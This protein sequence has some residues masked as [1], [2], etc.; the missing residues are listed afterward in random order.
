[1]I[2][3]RSF[4]GVTPQVIDKSLNL[5]KEIYNDDGRIYLET[6]YT[7]QHVE[8]GL[9]FEYKYVLAINDY[10]QWMDSI[11][12]EFPYFAEL[13]LIPTPESLDKQVLEELA[14]SNGVE[15]DEVL[16]YDLVIEG[17]SVMLGA[18][19]GL[20]QIMDR[21]TGNMTDNEVCEGFT[22]EDIP[23][24]INLVSNVISAIDMVRGFYLDR[25][26]NGVGWTGWDV[27]QELVSG[28]ELNYFTKLSRGTEED[29]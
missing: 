28:K 14:G 18:T 22:E 23:T 4:A 15:P 17:D 5:F 8:D 16:I 6:A 9:I 29:S 24:I 26:I 27:I 25:V 12:P 19:E 11:D 2:N 1:M 3:T 20:Y 21:N 10:A 7:Y 13:Y